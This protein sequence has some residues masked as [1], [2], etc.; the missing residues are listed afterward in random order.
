MIEVRV[1]ETSGVGSFRYVLYQREQYV[2]VGEMKGG[3]GRRMSRGLVILQ[4]KAPFDAEGRRRGIRSLVRWVF[5][6]PWCQE[7]WCLLL[8][9][10]VR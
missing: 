1:W 4:G 10:S 5:H 8:M 2:V 6:D 3:Q 7:E 9:A